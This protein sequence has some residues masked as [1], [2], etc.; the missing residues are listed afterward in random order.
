[1]FDAVWGISFRF[2]GVLGTAFGALASV[3]LIGCTL[4]AALQIVRTLLPAA[5]LPLRWSTSWSVGVWLAELGFHVL[6]SAHLLELPFALIACTALVCATRYAIPGALRFSTLAWHEQR[7]VTALFRL[8]KRGRHSVIAGC[9]LGFALLVSL[10][11][12]IVPPLGWDTLTYH[13]PRAALWITSNKFTFDAGVGSYDFYRHF[14]SGGEVLSAWAMLP[15]HSDMFLNLAGVFQWLGVGLA[16]WALARAIGLKEPFAATS[17]G[18]L[19]F[20]P[21]LQLEVNSGYVELALNSALL[22]G[23]ALAVYCMRRP[24]VQ[25]ALLCALALGVAAGIKL[26]GIPP[27]AIVAA[28]LA[29]RLLLSRQLGWREKL[30]AATGG[31]L[32][33]LLPPAPFLLRAWRDTGYPLSPM[34]VKLLGHTLGVASSAM[35]WY[36]DRPQLQ[37]YTWRAEKAALLALFSP[38]SEVNESLGLLCLI[39][40]LVFP[41]GLFALARRRPLVAFALLLALLAPVAAHFSPSIT[42][43]RL[44]RSISAARFL[45]PTIALVIP[46]SL[47]WCRRHDAL[48]Q[49]YRRL[50]LFYPLVASVVAVRRGWGDWETR[51]A[52]VIAITL[53]LATSLIWQLRRRRL[54]ATLLGLT[55]LTAGVV[56]LQ[57][58]RDDTRHQSYQ[59]GYAL[60]GFSRFWT[61]A[62]AIVDEVDRTHRIAITGGPDHSS[63]KWFYYF[64]LGARFQNSVQYVPPTRDGGVAHFGPH[65][66][67]DKRADKDSWVRRI[68][69][70]GITDVITFPPRSVEQSFMDA[71]PERF[72]QV[73]GKKDWGLYRL[74]AA[75]GY[76]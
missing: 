70:A 10:R 69:A 72:E 30:L 5:G 48:S 26:P 8:F 35:R 54:Q 14:I 62:P 51:D 27:A 34:P 41:I 29:L 42:A 37:A 68:V 56:L 13:G 40:L 44:L 19:M 33:A 49:A 76:D 67:L 4:L 50:L 57:A 59:K 45:V 52:T 15:F 43:V 75:G 63:D 17:A 18:A 32:V 66:D 71:T 74:K 28:V 61:E 47:A 11:S 46:I 24:S 39:P 3:W 23:I 21:T 25:G 65:G 6:R 12:L 64:F 1:M 20:A 36:Q 38:P 60:H 73:S 31:T 9:F 7:A 55:L 58:R 2:G 22:Q 53:M 16:S